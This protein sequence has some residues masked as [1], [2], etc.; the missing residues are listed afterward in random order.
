M[1]QFLDAMQF[2]HAC[3]AFD[4]NRAIDKEAFETLLEII[5]LSPSSFGMEPWRVLVVRDPKIRAKLKPLCWNQN[6]IT[7]ASELIIFTTD[8]RAVKSGSDY[9]R[10]MFE[11]RGLPEEALEKYLQVYDSYIAPLEGDPTLLQNWTAKQ[12][13]IAAAN[14]MTGAASMQI[15][16]CAIEGFDA[17]GVAALLDLPAHQTVALIVALGYRA[18]EQTPRARLGRD[19][20]VTIL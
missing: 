16:S 15:D 4:P 7:D 5:R 14:L 19:D 13:Y 11:R 3:K 10:M 20:I 2:R 9:R 8:N 1:S 6:Q 18:K 12:C 17:K